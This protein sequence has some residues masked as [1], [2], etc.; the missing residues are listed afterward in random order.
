[1][2]YDSRR[3]PRRGGALTAIMTGEA[4]RVSARDGG[5]QGPVPGLRAEPRADARGD[6]HAPRCGDAAST[7]T[8]CPHELLWRAARDA[9]NRAVQLGEQ[10]GYRNAQATVLAP[11]GTIGLLMDCDTTGVEPDFALVKFKKLAGG[12]YFKIVNQSVPRALKKLGYAPTRGAAPS[13]T[14]SRG[15][16]TLQRRAA[17]QP[18]RAE[19]ARPSPTEIARVEKSLP[20]RV[21]PAARRSRRWVIGADSA[22]SGSGSPAERSQAG[23]NAAGDARLHRRADRRGQRWWSAAGRRSK[24]RRASSRSTTPSSTAPTAAA[25]WA[26]ATSSPWATCG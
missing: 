6:A 2:P 17:L 20:E 7:A 23:F 8:R 3:R 18:R 4:Y 21:R 9:W 10:H 11:T 1:M 19:G 14:T 12:G 16:A 13:S 24:A 22:A 25:R 15:T 26:R 5:R